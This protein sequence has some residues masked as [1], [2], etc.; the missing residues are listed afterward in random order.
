MQDFE[1]EMTVSIRAAKR[2]A[3]LISEIYATGFSVE[4]K[5]HNDPVTVADRKANALLVEAVKAS[6]PDDYI[7]AEEDTT[8]SASEAASKGGRCWFIDPLDG[9]REFVDRN[10]EFCVMV[11][12]AVEGRA[13]LGVVVAPA[14]NRT[15]VG[16]TN[17]GA[18]EIS[19]DGSRRILRVTEG[20]CDSLAVSRAHPHAKVEAVAK[21]LGIQRM[22]PCG[23]V[24][25]KVCLVATGEVDGY[26]HFG[27]GPKLWDGCAPEA[28]A[29]GAGA[30][31]TESD[32]TPMRYNTHD[33]SLER[34]IVVAHPV[35]AQRLRDAIAQL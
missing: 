28:I 17:M 35:V 8:E 13:V 4:W 30:T 33:L 26:V 18:W 29:R 20:N 27:R 16:L 9:T 1:E 2:A 31:F 10:G 3:D 14:S 15:F 21:R 5:G 11:G 25:L 12:L 34:G 23:S 32:G 24:G 6:F 7:C 19:P 22:R